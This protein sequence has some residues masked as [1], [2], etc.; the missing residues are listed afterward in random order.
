MADASGP[1]GTAADADDTR[2]WIAWSPAERESFFDAIER[3][4]R[5]SWRV[6]AVCAL[7]I[8]ILTLVLAVLL[9]PLLICLAGLAVDL[10]KLRAIG[11]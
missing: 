5:A 9:A 4:R 10:V 3:H 7:A 11:H 6:T 1:T 8:A 2:G